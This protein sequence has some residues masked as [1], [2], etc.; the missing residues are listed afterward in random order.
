MDIQPNPR[1]CKFLPDNRVIEIWRYTTMGD[2]IEQ[3]TPPTFGSEATEKGTL[4]FYQGCVDA[5]NEKDSGSKARIEKRE[6]VHPEF[7]AGMSYWH[8]DGSGVLWHHMDVFQ[9][10]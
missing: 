9:V 8:Y 7:G 3:H 2:V 6:T 1:P 4:D 10:Q 5:A